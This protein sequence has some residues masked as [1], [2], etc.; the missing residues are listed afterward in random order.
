MKR[1]P[2]CRRDYY[3]E[4]LIYCL[5]DGNALLEGPAS[6]PNSETGARSIG[7]PKAEQR[8]A[9][10][11]EEGITALE[12]EFRT[13]PQTAILHSSSAPQGKFR[14]SPH[15]L[16][17]DFAPLV[18]RE[19]EIAEIECCLTQSEIRVLTLTG[20]GGTGKTR[21]AQAAAWRML[22]D[23]PDGVYFVNLAAITDFKLVT[24]AIAQT[25]GVKESGSGPLVDEIISHLDKKKIL[26]VLD[27]FE[28]VSEAASD[29]ERLVFSASG[30][31]VLITSRELLRL[32][33]ERE[34]AVP[35]LS[36]P[37][38]NKRSSFSDLSSFE[39]IRFFVERAQDIKPDFKLTEAN[40]ADVA[41]ICR[42]LDGLPFAIELAAARIKLFEPQTILTRLSDSLRFLTGG[43]KELPE[44]RQTMRGAI[45]WSYDLLE[46]GEKQVFKRLAIFAGG[47]TIDSAEAIGAD[48]GAEILDTVSSLLD[49][50]LIERM[51][52]QEG[53][54]RFRMLVVVREFALE[55]LERGDEG[56]DV[57]KRHAA[58]FADLAVRAEPELVGPRAAEWMA[59]LEQEHENIRAALQWTIENEPPTALKIGAS[60][61]RFWWRRSHLTE[62]V[63]WTERIIEA[64]RDSADLERLATA[65]RGISSLCWNRGDFE[66]AVA[67]AEKGL[68]IAQ[69]TGSKKLIINALHNVGTAKHNNGDIAGAQKFNEDALA[70][71]REAGE[72]FEAAELANALGELARHREDY[73]KAQTLYEETLHLARQNGYQHLHMIAAINLAAVACEMKDYHASHAYTLESMKISE[74][75][76]S[77]VSVGYALERFAALA[78][79][80]GEMERAARLSGAME[81]IYD[82]AGYKIEEVDRLFLERYLDEART[83]IGK[84]QFDAVQ[85]QGKALAVE[86]AIALARQNPAD[87]QATRKM[88]DSE[89]DPPF[90]PIAHPSKTSVR[91]SENIPPYI[92]EKSLSSAE[93][94]IGEV[95]RHRFASLAALLLIF[96]GLGSFGYFMF[97]RAE[98]INSVAVLPFINGTGNPDLDYLSDGLSENL[99]ND[100][101]RL[102]NLKVIARGSSFK[103]RGEN[104]DIQD[105][106]K[107]LGVG[108]I[109]TGR[110]SKRGDELQI[111][112][113]LV[114]ASDNSRIWGDIYNRSVS[115]AMNVPEEIVK[116]VSAKL[117]LGLS[118]TQEKQLEKHLTQDPVAYQS[119]MNGVFFRRMN[120]AENIRKAL[121]YQNKAVAEDPNFARAYAEISI[122]YA[123]LV[124]IGEMSTKDGIPQARAA[125][126]RA[127]ELDNTLAEAHYAL[128][129]VKTYEFDW[130]A[131]ETG[132]RK[133]I[134]LNPNL[135]AVHTLYADYLS[136]VGRTDDALREI[137]L[138]KEL[139]PLRIGLVG[140]EGNIYYLAR[141]FDEAAAKARDHVGAA[142]DNP[143][144][145]L[146]LANA[147]VEKR[148][149]AEAIEQYR[150]VLK[151]EE[152]AS[153]LV[154]LGRA[155]ALSGDQKGAEQ[156][157]ARLRSAKSYVSPAETAILYAALSDRERAF[158]LLEN[159]Y[160]ER[161][162][163]LALL[164]VDPAFDPLRN[165]QRF[166]EMLKRL[167]FPD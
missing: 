156:M 125:A 132:F 40:A 77:S 92:T 62:G 13:E 131:A 148:Q 38:E 82:A 109:L 5:D 149:F 129:R 86:D 95:N 35:P 22:L 100:L 120:G 54:P 70:M 118:G 143:F 80:G 153:G 52:R 33:A 76:G 93:Y 42:R 64:N 162:F 12:F 50:N 158:E 17:D 90:G 84:E 60:A 45:L 121:N 164:K 31:R 154:Y 72:T 128:A 111:S 114:N 83:K 88:N 108:A 4:T 15:N 146:N 144:A 116:S 46:E 65:Y 69:K 20:V 139:D 18:G 39:S 32:R 151:L 134:D 67:F 167:N 159:A 163:R 104:V 14:A 24:P 113:E 110:I 130:N 150:T 51:H 66:R 75:M 107:K 43:G 136:I 137:R 73:A 23:F 122:N 94:I 115:G 152:T 81:A 160:A 55:Q 1:C 142:P 166:A 91:S 97:I 85:R 27:N 99:I 19:K 53:E 11:S 101:S 102:P 21:L 127:L 89:I 8:T 26:L 126:E 58:F 123:A 78:V 56:V 68:E 145:Y 30:V 138:A 36:L 117:N 61:Q 41:E 7:S 155:F 141:R 96:V 25:L 79:I 49:K 87:W 124:E 29:I 103:Y 10:L 3:D 44:R 57:R 119:Y 133:A 98:P 105:A 59:T 37:A 9:I 74:E 147:L 106:A 157:L 48:S 6:S 161:D 165:D 34:F 140:N 16:T 135:A 63:E 47:F 112:A 28:Q 71:A 2:E